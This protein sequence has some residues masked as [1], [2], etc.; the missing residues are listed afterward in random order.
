MLKMFLVTGGWSRVGDTGDKIDSTEIYDPDFGRW[1]GG[2]A[3][4]SKRGALGA[5]NID[6]RVLL[7]GI[8]ILSRMVTKGQFFI[9]TGGKPLTK[10]GGSFNAILEYDVTADSFTEIG[11]MTQARGYH[12]ISV[13]RYEDF[14]KGCP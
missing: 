9:L 5:T 14:S 10:G 8:N 12:A 1:T 3:L 13:V 7:F 4:P 11:T 6:G 2:A